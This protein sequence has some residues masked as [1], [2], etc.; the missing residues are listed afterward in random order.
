[1]CSQS[2]STLTW[3][4]S[5]LR[6]YPEHS[7]D[8][9]VAETRA[10]RC[11]TFP[12]VFP[13]QRQAKAS[14]GDVVCHQSSIEVLF[15]VHNKKDLARHGVH[16]KVVQDLDVEEPVEPR[17]FTKLFDTLPKEAA[18]LAASLRAWPISERWNAGV[19]VRLVNSAYSNPPTN[20]ITTDLCKVF[21]VF[22]LC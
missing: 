21:R 11:W 18:E 14:V 3:D 13:N 2:R 10:L 9:C 6:R 1:M 16:C 15:D 8:D 12:V 5:A 4:F 7:I 19:E 22:R 20:H 17:Y